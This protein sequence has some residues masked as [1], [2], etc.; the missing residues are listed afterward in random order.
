MRI[1]LIGPPGA[2]K[3]TQARVLADGPC[4]G[5]AELQTVPLGRVVA[6]GEHHPGDGER[7]RRG[8]QEIGRREPEVPHVHAPGDH[9]LADPCRERG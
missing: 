6:G 7:A 1:V 4:S 9:A 2:G 5:E 3:G 8:V